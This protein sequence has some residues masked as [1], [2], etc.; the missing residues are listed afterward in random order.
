MLQQKAA[1]M[2]NNHPV[3]ILRLVF[4]FFI[5]NPL[6]T[7]AGE[8]ISESIQAVSVDQPPKIDGRA[9]EEV[10][11]RAAKVDQFIQREPDTGQPASRKTEF[12]VCHDRDNLYI[13]AK[14]YDDPELI[15]A[16]QLERDASLGNDDK[17]VII[18][19]TFLDRRNAFWFQMN[20][21]GC[22]GD[23][24]LSQNGASL[25]KDWDGLWEGRA[26]IHAHGWDMEA[27]IPFKT[28]NFHPGQD[29]WGIKFEREI[30]R[31][32]EKS[33]WPVANVNSYKFQVSDAGLLTGLTSISQGIGLDLRPYVLMG[34]E[35]ERGAD[36]RFL[37]DGG[38]DLFYQ[39]TPGL[40]TALTLNTDF[41]Q[42]E[43]DD[44][45]INLT[46]FPLFFPEKRDFFL[47]GANYYQFGREG[48]RE[49]SYANRLIL[50]FSRRIGLDSQ[51]N[52]IP[53]IAGSKITGQA[54][55]WN[56]GFMDVADDRAQCITNFAVAR[57]SRNFGSQSALGVIGTSGNAITDQSNV[58]FGVDL[59]LATSTFQGDKNLSLL[60]YG[61]KSNTGNVSGSDYAFGGEV[62]YPNDF[63]KCRLGYTQIEKNFHAGL[64]FVPRRGI[65][66][67]YVQAGL[68]PR[69]QQWG[70]LQLLFQSDLDFITDLDNR[71]LSRTCSLTPL[72]IRFQSGDLLSLQVQNHY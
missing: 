45:Q 53:I 46:R 44:R 67:S 16:L 37:S 9:V 34:T 39:I 20:A 62:N 59:K 60:L 22:I 14:C 25:N 29:T 12:F 68:G 2:A 55:P 66:N 41:A 51:R 33:Y 64:G 28:L 31:R 71:Q 17:I 57:I 50:F 42:T 8:I 15:T 21:R 13:A 47:D 54:G 5:A 63:F 27:A 40:K 30:Q 11:S 69:P 24:L 1:R 26:S 23:A 56:I 18:L 61:V 7:T 36:S 10:W 35:K 70:I 38:L 4:L 49:N 6:F 65:R 32:T 58:L 52:P 19:D 3:K 48:D 43:V 72:S